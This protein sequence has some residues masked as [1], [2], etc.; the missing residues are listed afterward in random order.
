[1][2]RIARFQD[3]HWR[4]DPARPVQWIWRDG[5][6]E[7]TQDSI[8]VDADVLLDEAEAHELLAFLRRVLDD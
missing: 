8:D 3:Y 4:V 5:R 7:L 6:L 1:M 2:T